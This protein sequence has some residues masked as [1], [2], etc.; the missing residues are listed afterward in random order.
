M[1]RVCSRGVGLSI[2][3]GSAPAGW[4][5][6]RGV[7]LLTRG[8][9]GDVVG[10]GYNV[11]ANSSRRYSLE[12]QELLVGRDRLILPQGAKRDLLVVVDHCS[13]L[14]SVPLRNHE[15]GGGGGVLKKCPNAG[16]LGFSLGGVTAR[17]RPYYGRPAT[18][19]SPRM[20]VL[21]TFFMPFLIC[22]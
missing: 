21:G 17:T 15:K 2:L 8:G 22:S 12:S 6:S 19:N 7:G 1:S 3:I 5:C 14:L 16:A 10:T 9:R 18:A 13:L 20:N 11:N 4:V